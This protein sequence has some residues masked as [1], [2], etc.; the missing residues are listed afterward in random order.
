VFY[1]SRY[2]Y[3]SLHRYRFLLARLHIDSLL[4][5]R[6]KSKVQS[7]LETL[8][9]GSKALDEAYEDAI[10]R[11]KGQLP[12][13]TALASRVLSWITYAQRA[14]TT[15]EIRHALAVELDESSLNLDNLLDVEDIVSVCAGLVTIDEESNIIR[16]VHYTTQEYFERIRDEWNPS[17]QL[18]ITSICLTYL[19]FDAFKGGAC[20]TDQDFEKRLQQNV[21]L[22][23]AAKHWGQ[24]AVTVQDKIYELAC[25]FL[26][27]SRLVSSAMQAMLVS[28]SKYKGYSRES[29][30]QSTGL[31]LIVRFR[32]PRI[33]V[34]LFPRL[35]D[36]V[37][38]SINARDGHN[39]APLLLAARD[40]HDAMVE[41]LLDKGAEVNAQG[42]VD[43]N[44]LQAA[45][46][47]GYEQ[48]VKL[49]LDK[50]AEVNA[51]GGDYGNALQAASSRGHEKV[52]KLLLNKGAEVNAQGGHYGNALQAASSRGHEKVV[53][54]L[55]NKGAEVNAQG[56]AYG[57]ALQAASLGGY[58]QVVK[59]LLDKGAEVNAQG[60]DYGS[61]LQAAS[62]GGYEQVVKL[63]L[64]KGAE[65][66][67]Q[68]GLICHNALQA[69][70]SRGHE[71]IVKLLLDKGAE[72]N[73]QGGHYGN[74]LQAAS[75][76]GHEQIVKLLLGKSAEVNA[77]GGAY[78]NA[79]QAASY[80][81]H[82]QVVKLPSR[83]APL[84]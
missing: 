55:L 52:V 78:G 81:G 60:G 3:S 28:D 57:N 53:K 2:S 26:L 10:E 31:H 6:T 29:P 5:K 65:V 36:K 72:V 21:F 58:E 54:L 17:A 56:G 67:A 39:R 79:L 47:R 42:G 45:S 20:S 76:R 18:D 61:A 1:V 12:E 68:G 49:L 77:Q 70:S 33:L 62:L 48:V 59:L 46:L 37:E 4:D 8:S 74:A 71:Q 27:Q 25:I 41:L 30:T 40:G 34:E 15:E 19:C 14:L 82:E 24:H 43:G 35:E 23:Y 66:N 38:V 51:Q 44:A 83:V 80:R 64:N 73:P 9:M 11:I 84:H 16:L 22:D 13:D 50:G 69:A 63:L 32:L 7:T 75:S